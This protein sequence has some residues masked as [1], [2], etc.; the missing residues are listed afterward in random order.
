[1]EK[2]REKDLNMRLRAKAWHGGSSFKEENTHAH[3]LCLAHLGD[4]YTHTYGLFWRR[5]RTDILK[6]Q[7]FPDTLPGSMIVSAWHAPPSGHASPACSLL[8]WEHLH[9]RQQEA[10]PFPA[11][12][13][14]S[15]PL[16]L[17]HVFVSFMAF[18]PRPPSRE[19]TGTG[20]GREKRGLEVPLSHTHFEI[21]WNMGHIRNCTLCPTFL[22]PTQAAWEISQLIAPC[23]NIFLSHPS[24]PSRRAGELERSM[25]AHCM[26]ASLAWHA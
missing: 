14:T 18:L 6:I 25:A 24:R 9:Y 4:T 13:T 3:L 22:Y 26:A 21:R 5:D 12:H 17:L 8:C 2:V 10:P 15:S 19:R 11:S 1:M 20:R 16:F 7:H 23:S